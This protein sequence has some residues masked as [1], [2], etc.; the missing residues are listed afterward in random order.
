MQNTKFTRLWRGVTVSILAMALMPL[1]LA[2]GRSLTIE[3]PGAVAAGQQFTV[4]VAASTDAGGGE[5]IGFLQV[6]ASMDEGKTWS[7][8]AFL[9][10]LEAS[11]RQEIYLKSDA[12]GMVK[13]RA[14][15]AFRDGLA[16]DVDY[17]GAAILWDASWSD[18][19]QPP[20]KIASIKVR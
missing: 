4:A 1:S 10:N 8:M 19:G 7:A 11:H 14:R 13:V 20:A 9:D 17:T 16:G 3:A 12:S 5:R 6:E 15:V 2:V 18:W